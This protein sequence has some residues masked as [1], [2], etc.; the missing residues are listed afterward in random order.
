MTYEDWARARWEALHDAPDREPTWD[1]DCPPWYMDGG[2][3]AFANV[4]E[5]MGPLHTWCHALATAYYYR[6]RDGEKDGDVAGD[7]KK[8]DWWEGNARE[9]AGA[10][11]ERPTVGDGSASWR[12]VV[13][14]CG[15]VCGSPDW[16][17]LA[18]CRA[19]LAQ[20]LAALGA[21]VRA[22]MDLGCTEEC[23]ANDGYSDCTCG[24]EDAESDP[25]EYAAGVLA[26]L[27][28]VRS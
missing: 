15:G 27:A 1:G 2:N 9:I 3:E 25:G 6:L 7:S 21:V 26:S 4:L 28:G 10:M 16:A 11:P 18:W 20:A 17:D 14:R 13:R 5:A 24:Y 22:S 23:A 12:G 19:D 8:A